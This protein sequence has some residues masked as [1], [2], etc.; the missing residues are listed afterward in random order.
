MPLKTYK[1]YKNQEYIF[2]L[3][4]KIMYF[5]KLDKLIRK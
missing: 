5:L 2:N 4:A 3:G 1:D